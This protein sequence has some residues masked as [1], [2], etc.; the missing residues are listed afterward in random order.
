MK[1]KTGKTTKNGNYILLLGEQNLSIRD[2]KIE[3]KMAFQIISENILT[4]K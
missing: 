3:H 4:I 2:G 1:I